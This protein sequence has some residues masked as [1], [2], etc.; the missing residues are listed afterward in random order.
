MPT[1][2]IAIC[3]KAL[4][5]LGIST[6]IQ[7]ITEASKE[8]RACA[9]FYSDVIETSL[10]D[11]PWGFASVLASLGA[12]VTIAT[13]KE[14]YYSYRMPPDCLTLIRLL[15]GSRI[16][17]EDSRVPF[18]K[19]HDSQGTIILTDLTDAY[20]EY[21][22]TVTDPSLFPADFADAAALLLAGM[23]APRV[24]KGDDF[25][26]GDRALKL[27]QWRIQSAQGN[28]AGEQAFDKE[29]DTGSIRARN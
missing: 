21:T 3:N 9:R 1:S 24:T 25:K 11:Y 28:E 29:P 18:K 27:Y 7:D 6:E 17:T 14:W 22:S 4:S 13:N 16:D 8:A 10:R 2:Q 5:H 20:A 26:L 23:I 15:S 19:A 12:P